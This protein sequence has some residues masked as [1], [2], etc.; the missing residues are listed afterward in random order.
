[1]KR[2]PNAAYTLEFKLEALRRV[3]GGEPV[4]RIAREITAGKLRQPDPGNGSTRRRPAVT[5]YPEAKRRV[6]W[7][8]KDEVSRLLNALPSHQRQPARFA[9]ATGL[10][11]ASVLQLKWPEV[12]LAR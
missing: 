10:R 11:Q 5:L 6:R 8:N 3:R 2:I 9:L 1:M 4:R 12:D 7:L